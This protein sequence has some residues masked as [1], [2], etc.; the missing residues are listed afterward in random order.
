MT[1]RT[2]QQDLVIKTSI[3]INGEF[4]P[5]E[6]GHKELPPATDSFPGG[7]ELRIKGELFIDPREPLDVLVFWCAVID[8]LTSLTEGK[9]YEWTLGQPRSILVRPGSRHEVEIVLTSLSRGR[10][11]VAETT[12]DRER[13]IAEMAHHAKQCL[14]VRSAMAPQ[15]SEFLAGAYQALAPFLVGH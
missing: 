8:M 12:F 13:F 15:D 2:S 14:D 4:L 3:M 9:S 10:R 11:V 5:I 6:R 1:K 7:I